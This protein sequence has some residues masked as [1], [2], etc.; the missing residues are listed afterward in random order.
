MHKF[1]IY[2]LLVCSLLWE[3]CHGIP[4]VDHSGGSERFDVGV[5]GHGESDLVCDDQICDDGGCSNVL[6][7]ATESGNVINPYKFVRGTKGVV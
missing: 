5:E 2:A 4:Y 1:S 6:N 7:T 3:G